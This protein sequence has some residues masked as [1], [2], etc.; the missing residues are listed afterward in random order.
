LAVGILISACSDRHS[1]YVS[2]NGSDSNSGS[3]SKPF[4]SIQQAQK[5]VA[6]QL[7]E[8]QSSDIIVFIGEGT[9]QLKSPIHFSNEDSGLGDHQVIYKAAEGAS[10]ILSGGVQIENWSK[11]GNGLWSA[12]IPNLGNTNWA[13]RELFID[14]ERGIR[15]RHPNLDY[16]RV[17]KVG[18]DRRTNFFFKDGDFPPPQRVSNVELIL[19]HDWSISRIAVKQIDLKK[20]QLWAV[21]SIGAILN[22]FTLDHWEPQPRYFLENDM[23]FLDQP[24]EWYYDHEQGK[25]YLILPDGGDPNDLSIIA[26]FAS[27]L[28][29]IKGSLSDKARNLTFEGITFEHTNWLPSSRGYLGVQACHYDTRIPGEGWHVVP[30]AIE[31]SYAENCIF[32]RCEFRHLGGGGL[33]MGIDAKS[34]TVKNSHFYD[35]S[36]NGIMVGEGQHRK[37]GENSWWLEDP[38][39]IALGNTIENCTVTSVGQQFFGAVGIWCGLTAET[40]I[41]NNHIHN[42]PYT[43]VSVGWMWNAQSTPCRDNHITNN[44]IHHVMQKLSDGGGIYM[45]GKQPGSEIINN[46]IHNV[47]L[48]VGKA[49]SN[50][51]F[52]DEGTTDVIVSGNII[53]EIAKSPLRFHKAFSNLVTKNTMVV[54][55][56]VPP[57]RYNRTKEEDIRQVDNLILQHDNVEDQKRLEALVEAWGRESE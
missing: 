48:N 14:G 7:Q 54:P 46:H 11:S 25:I 28:L 47:D 16:L 44:H 26:P 35:I 39:Q 51:M 24:N 17:D 31:I 38:T 42:L 45:L 3:K 13:L 4:A 50:G 43:G 30:S 1:Y 23:A 8:G 29:E 10:P 12:E 41:S 27:N 22:F 56:G 57:I 55:E 15:A 5:A 40:T 9:Y 37:I 49:E 2:L 32:D 19:L 21:D 33:R 53:Y 36:A 6:N 34:C 20:R 18:E 52:L